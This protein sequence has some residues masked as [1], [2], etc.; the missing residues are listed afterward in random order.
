MPSNL[1]INQG[2]FKITDLEFKAA[3]AFEDHTHT[4]KCFNIFW[5]VTRKK[6]VAQSQYWLSLS[7]AKLGKAACFK[8]NLKVDLEF[9]HRI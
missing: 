1:G 6:K 4:W 2:S 7:R 9:E 3:E 5:T 8:G